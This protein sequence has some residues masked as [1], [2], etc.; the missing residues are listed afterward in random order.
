[1]RSENKEEN[2]PGEG[3]ARPEVEVGLGARLRKPGS[4]GGTGISPE[5]FMDPESCDAGL[6]IMEVLVGSKHALEHLG[7]RCGLWD[8]GRQE[9]RS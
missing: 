1:M 7:K 3:S 4:G 8:G 6:G 2:S 5:T 9:I